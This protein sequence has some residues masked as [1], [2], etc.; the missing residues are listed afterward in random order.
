MHIF[1]V[2]VIVLGCIV[3]HAKRKPND[4]ANVNCSAL[5]GRQDWTSQTDEAQEVLGK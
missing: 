1:K 2:E 5:L 3:K 4:A